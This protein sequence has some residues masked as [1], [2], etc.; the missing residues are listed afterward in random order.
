MSFQDTELDS[1]ESSFEEDYNEEPF[2][3]DTPTEE[4]EDFSSEEPSFNEPDFDE[5]SFDEPSIDED[6]SV[7]NEFSI[8][9]GPSFKEPTFDGPTFDEP[10]LEEPTFEEP[11]LNEPELDIPDTIPEPDIPTSVVEQSDTPETISVSI[12]TKDTK[13]NSADAGNSLPKENTSSIQ[14]GLNMEDDPFLA[15]ADKTSVSEEKEE[16]TDKN[17]GEGSSE[18]KKV[19]GTKDD[20]LPE[21]L[22]PDIPLWK[23]EMEYVFKNTVNESKFN[24]L[25]LYKRLEVIS[26]NNWDTPNGMKDGDTFAV[27]LEN[28]NILLFRFYEREVEV[29]LKKGEEFSRTLVSRPDSAY[30]DFKTLK[31]F[32]AENQ[33]SNMGMGVSY[34]K[35]LKRF[36]AD[37]KPGEVLVFDKGNAYVCVDKEDQYIQLKRTCSSFE[38]GFSFKQLFSSYYTFNIN[39]EK[40]ADIQRFYE[41]VKTPT[42]DAVNVRIE[43]LTTAQ[44]IMNK[45][46]SGLGPGKSKTVDFGPIMFHIKRARLSKAIKWYSDKGE[47][48]PDI[49]VKIAIAWLNKAPVITTF[50]RKETNAILDFND[51]VVKNHIETLY[52][53][54]NFKEAFRIMQSYCMLNNGSL[55][56]KLKTYMRGKGMKYKGYSYVFTSKGLFMLEYAD[57]DFTKDPSSVKRATEEMF[58]DFCEAKYDDAYKVIQNS[59]KNEI[60]Q[61]YPNATKEMAEKIADLA[62]KYT[63][64]KTGSLIQETDFDVEQDIGAFLDSYED[65]AENMSKQDKEE[66]GLLSFEQLIHNA[67]NHISSSDKARDSG[68]RESRGDDR[69]VNGR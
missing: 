30:R 37:L 31:K 5:P 26:R 4:L 63:L 61:K 25:H 50:S 33:R 23:K 54:G 28:N 49:N 16:D 56:I 65:K 57:G 11:T 35:K 53:C 24:L 13:N 55:A 64:E 6:I 44:E 59:K 38:E 67:E 3:N 14:V 66:I 43:L 68:G 60:M 1:F 22:L 7:D 51:S 21:D 69:E 19:G 8:D 52:A 47:L 48:I 15:D 40:D 29:I 27:R 39:M 45:C 36:L 32:E 17:E 2:F 46:M 9:E 20:V 18:N 58:Y 41:Q 10:D 42:T 12:E 62:T 34:P